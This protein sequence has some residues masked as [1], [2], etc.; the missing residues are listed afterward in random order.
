M[1]NIWNHHLDN[2]N[3][4]H[5]DSLIPPQKNK[6][7]TT[8]FDCKTVHR[9]DVSVVAFDSTF[10]SHSLQKSETSKNGTRFS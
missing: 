3:Q 5:L 8:A 2:S 10:D 4:F 6:D 1:V 9:A 7:E